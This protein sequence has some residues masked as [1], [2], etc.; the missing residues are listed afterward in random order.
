MPWRRGA[1]RTSRFLDIKISDDGGARQRRADSVV[2]QHVEGADGALGARVRALRTTVGPVPTRQL[3]LASSTSEEVMGALA[4]L[5]AEIGL[6][7]MFPAEVAAEAET[8]VHR[9]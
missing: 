9:D 7:A 5:R 8:A 3:R 2:T 1:P 6:P 4:A